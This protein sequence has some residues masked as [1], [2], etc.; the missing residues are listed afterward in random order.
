MY[1]IYNLQIIYNIVFAGLMQKHTVQPVF[2]KH[3]SYVWVVPLTNQSTENLRI[4][5]I[6]SVIIEL[7]GKV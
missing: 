7:S 6:F 1:I 5:L 3:D 4:G 2:H